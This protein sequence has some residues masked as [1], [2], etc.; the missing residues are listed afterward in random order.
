[1]KRRRA[2]ILLWLSIGLACRPTPERREP[3]RMHPSATAAPAP[4]HLHTAPRGGTL[5]EVGEEF[6][7][8]E[9]VLDSAAGRLTAFVLDGEAE[10]SVRI[11]QPAIALTVRTDDG[12]SVP[13]ELQAVSQPLTGETQGDCSQFSGVAPELVSNRVSSGSIAAL[14]VR[15][16]TFRDI[17]FGE[18]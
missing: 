2:A 3:E 10:A 11:A 7:H 12:G 5:V 13:V 9:L 1:M 6:A 14:T 8:V 17:A 4:A 15:G 16:R 18:R